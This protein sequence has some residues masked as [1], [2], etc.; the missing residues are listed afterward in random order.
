MIIIPEQI[1]L[2]AVKGLLTLIDEK[3]LYAVFGDL[4]LPGNNYNYFENAKE[5]F[6]TR[7]N[8]SPRK[9]EANLFFNRNRASLPTIHI[10]L[11]GEVLGEGNGIGFD[12]SEDFM[13][14]TGLE[15]QEYFS[16]TYN[17]R[18]NMVFTSN[19]TFEV[20]IMY[21]VMRC[22][23]QGNVQVLEESG[24][25]NCKFSGNDLNLSDYLTPEIYARALFIDCIYD[26]KAPSLSLSRGV[27][28]SWCKGTMII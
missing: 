24:L 19:N 18:Y 14:E 7:D 2:Q 4:Q 5:I 12:P 13:T 6:L 10:G 26:I 11:P 23:L 17:S 9:I 25:R 1:I 16:R 20:L 21:N 28:D 15:I 8:T 27:T 3:Y 22:L